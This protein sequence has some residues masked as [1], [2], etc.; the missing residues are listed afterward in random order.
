MHRVTLYFSI[1]YVCLV[2]LSWPAHLQSGDNLTSIVT[3]QAIIN[4]GTMLIDERYQAKSDQRPHVDIEG[5]TYSR[6]GIGLP[7]LYLPIVVTSNLLSSFIDQEIAN[8][9]L[10]S[11]VPVTFGI[12]HF[13]LLF[14]VMIRLGASSPKAIILTF[15]ASVFTLVFRY[16]VYDHSEI[17]QACL[18]MG[19]LLLLLER[20]QFYQLSAFSLLSLTV[21]I[22][23][24]NIAIFGLF[25]LLAIYLCHERKNNI[26]KTVLYAGIPLLITTIGI[27]VLNYQR[28]GAIL[29]SGYGKEVTSFA[30]EYFNRDFWKL[31]FSFEM[32]FFTFSPLLLLGVAG[33]ILKFKNRKHITLPALGVFLFLWLLS[34]FFYEPKGAWSLGPRYIVP[35]I[36]FLSLGLVFLNYQAR[37]V[38]ITFITL[39]TLA[40]ILSPIYVLQKT[41]EYDVIRFNLSEDHSRLPAQIP[42][43]AKLLWLKSQGYTD[44][45]YPVSQFTGEDSQTIYNLTDYQT[46]RAVNT[47]YSHFSD[48]LGIPLRQPFLAIHLTLFLAAYLSVVISL[49][50]RKSPLLVANPSPQA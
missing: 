15:S 3:A 40:A 18:F 16:T 48:K 38:R 28:Y 37:L 30:F 23:A 34:A 6:F 21:L 41:Q 10:F 24:Y 12:I 22:K 11:A 4:E 5:K 29:E 1:L 35:A 31:L 47:W 2:A 13:Y 50:H 20:R 17:I 27:F 44:Q 43:L 45:E 25:G 42:G 33:M 46:Y 26:W 49:L 36:P 8:H 14:L 9:I 39:L 32:G 7:L 19:A